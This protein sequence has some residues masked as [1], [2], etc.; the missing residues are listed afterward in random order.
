MQTGRQIASRLSELGIETAEALRRSHPDSIRN[1]FSV[2]LSRTVLEL[3]GVSCL[4]LETV[5]PSK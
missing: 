5:T 3:N 4:S 2:V 1:Q